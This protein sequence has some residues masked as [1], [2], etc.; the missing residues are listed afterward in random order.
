MVVSPFLVHGTVADASDRFARR[1]FLHIIPM[2]RK[3]T[4]FQ[5][6]TNLPLVVMV[7]FS[8][9]EVCFTVSHKFTIRS[10]HMFHT[11]I[12]INYTATPYLQNEPH[13]LDAVSEG[14]SRSPVDGDF[15]PQSKISKSQTLS[16]AYLQH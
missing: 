16:N 14:L 12:P 1:P 10:D 13:L 4:H 15:T 5:P 3:C 11:M 2:T 8:V 9:N 6:S 7:T